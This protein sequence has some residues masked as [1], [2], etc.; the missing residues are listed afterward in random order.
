MM[1]YPGMPSGAMQTRY[2]GPASTAEEAFN[3]GQI[4]GQAP[5]GGA[6]PP[7]PYGG[8]PAPYYP[9]QPPPPGGPPP[10]G[11]PW[12]KECWNK[13]F[14]GGPSNTGI[15]G[16]WDARS[17]QQ[18]KDFISPVSSPTLFEDP[19][20]LT[21]FRLI[22]GYQKAPGD[23]PLLRGGS[24]SDLNLQG[25]ISINADRQ[26]KIVP[27]LSGTVAKVNKHRRLPLRMA[28]TAR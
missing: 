23:N 18:F 9:G 25:R 1:S 16:T 22:F 24:I 3:C 7:P 4:P 20:S 27:K 12:Y 11:T 5:A 17:D 21:E 6:A 14:G 15:P 2:Q 26:A 13:I 8:Q 19:R 10:S 28:S